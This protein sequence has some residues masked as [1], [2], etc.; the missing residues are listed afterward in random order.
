MVTY[1]IWDNECKRW[2]FAGDYLL[3]ELLDLQQLQHV[4]LQNLSWH[5]K[6]LI[7]SKNVIAHHL[8]ELE[9]R[10]RVLVIAAYQLGELPPRQLL[11]PLLLLPLLEALIF[12]LIRIFTAR[13]RL[14]LESPTVVKY[15]V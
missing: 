9:S 12:I 11:L 7:K 5:C 13:V 4:L 14:S 2:L 8:G 15:F 1:D 6:G 3:R 10:D